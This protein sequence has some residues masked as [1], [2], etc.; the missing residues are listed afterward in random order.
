MPVTLR[1]FGATD[2]GGAGE[3][4]HSGVF[5]MTGSGKSGLA[6]Y[7]IAT[8][9]RRPELGVIIIDPQGQ[10]F[11]ERQLPFSLGEFAELIGRRVNRYAIAQDIRLPQSAPLLI[12]LLAL[13]SVVGKTIS[14]HTKDKRV[15]V[16]DEFERILKRTKGWPE[17]DAD[18]VLREMFRK[19]AEDQ[20]ALERVYSG[21]EQRERLANTLSS[22]VNDPD[23]F[24][25]AAEEFRPIHS[26]FAPSNMDGGKRIHLLTVLEEILNPQS[27]DRPLVILDFS[28]RGEGAFETELLETTP[29]KARLL[30]RVCSTLNRRAEGLFREDRGLNVL[31]VFDEAHRFA[32]ESSDDEQAAHLANRL[33]DYVR[34]TRKFGLGWMFITQEIGSLKRSIFSQLRARCF[35]YGLTSGTELSR[36]Q[37]VVGD[38]SAVDLY[39]SF[40]DPGAVRPR[41]FPFM[42]TGPISPLSFTGAPLFLSVYTDHEA[43]LKANEI[44]P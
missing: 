2:E 32:A 39:K 26:L 17:A 29:V 9:L 23:Q 15:A 12:E 25:I 1:H 7:L 13:T 11:A 35:G 3:A 21:K 41:E 44:A 8:Y 42:L 10:F 14:I 16:A 24:Q 31:V 34:T 6:A 33:V 43:F 4:Y 19:L 27:R 36:L 5:G 22:L 30:H 28:R 37:E 38:K 40:V 18:E 20:Q